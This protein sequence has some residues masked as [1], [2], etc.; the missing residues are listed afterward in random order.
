MARRTDSGP[1][2]RQRAVALVDLEPRDGTPGLAETLQRLCRA[3]THDLDLAGATVTLVPDETSHSVLAASG[4][5]VRRTEERQFDAGEGPTH[6]AFVTGEPVVVPRLQG[7]GSR[8]PEFTQEAESSGVSSVASLPL[9]VGA[10]RLGSLSLYWKR[11]SGPTYEDL[12]SAL[13]FA[14]LATELLIDSSCSPTSEDL[15]PGLHSALQTHGHIYQ[16][17]GMLMVA[18]GVHLP[19]ALARMRAHAF[20]TGQDLEGVA[21]QILEGELVLTRDPP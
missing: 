21:E 11:G 16:A 4:E 8:W 9:C 7:A 3:V 20:A 17:Q 1:A 15:D 13:V 19:E 6:R 10:A 18:L 2:P 14:D 12:R 5:Q